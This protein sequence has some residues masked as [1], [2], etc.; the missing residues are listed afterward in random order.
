MSGPTTTVTVTGILDGFYRFATSTRDLG[1]HFEQRVVKIGTG[2]RRG[3]GWLLPSSAQRN[4]LAPRI[5]T[6]KPNVAID[7]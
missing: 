1:D 7:H 6:S 3:G 2:A 4:V 5:V